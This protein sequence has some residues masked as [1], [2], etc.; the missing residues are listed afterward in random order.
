MGML[1]RG[2][3]ERLV[4]VSV[5]RPS[6]VPTILRAGLLS[7]VLS[8]LACAGA[9]RQAEPQSAL[10]ELASAL[11]RGDMEAAYALMSEDYRARH[12]LDD[13]TK[14]IAGNKTEARALSEAL[15]AAVKTRN[16]AEVELARGDRI[17][18]ESQGGR[19]QFV[20][21][22]VDFYPQSTPREALRSFVHAVEAQRWDVVL[23]LMPEA[24]R[25]DLSAETLGKNLVSQREELERLVA[26]L[27]ASMDSPIEQVSDRATM[28][29][30]ESFTARFVREAGGWKIEDPE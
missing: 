20:T 1:R 12:A 6:G 5:H 13:F 24:A 22:V 2:L 29:Y 11:R 15:T 8:A 18:L 16:Y 17:R 21:P 4:Y 26:L 10:R 25:G 7:L 28:P 23:A 27:M 30:G 19:W 3:G 14:E 9:N